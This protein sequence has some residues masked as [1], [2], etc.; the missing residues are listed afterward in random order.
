QNIEGT[1]EI[2]ESSRGTMNTDIGAELQSIENDLAK[3]LNID[4]GVQVT[5][6]YPGLLRSETDMREGF[7]IMKIN[8]KNVRTPEDV[9]KI[10]Q[11]TKGG[12]M[13]EGI[14]EEEPERIR[15]FAFGI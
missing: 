1:T 9:G 11:N 15:Y 12:V 10:L 6:L 13:I 14:Y 5:R 7:I 4:A 2:S 3:K 8:G